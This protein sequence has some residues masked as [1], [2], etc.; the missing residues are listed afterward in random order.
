[1]HES[2]VPKSGGTDHIS[3]CHK[4]FLYHVAKGNRIN[5]GKLVFDHLLEA[6]NSGKPKLGSYMCDPH[7]INGTTLRYLKLIKADKIYSLSHQASAG[8]RN[9]RWNRRILFCLC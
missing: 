9:I 6:I 1:M 4:M 8:K 2:I 5:T 7:I 3:V